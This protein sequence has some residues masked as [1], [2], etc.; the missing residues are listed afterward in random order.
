MSTTPFD[1]RDQ[2]PF[3]RVTYAFA[4]AW[5]RMTWL[6]FTGPQARPRQW[7][8]WG[9]LVLLSGAVGSD[10]GSQVLFPGDFSS[11]RRAIGLPGL[12]ELRFLVLLLGVGSLLAV[13]V[14][15]LT[16]R[17]GFALLEAVLSGRPRLRG[18]FASTA[19]P[20]LQLF[21]AQ[22]VAGLIWLVLLVPAIVA[23]WPAIGSV[24]N[25]RS[26]TGGAITLLI[27]AVLLWVL[28]LGIVAG[29]FMWWLNDLVIPIAW[30]RGLSVSSAMGVAARI[31][32]SNLGAVLLMAL[33]RL[34]V[35]IA[36]G[37]F[38]A[39]VMCA[40]CCF[41]LPFAGAA[42]WM[43][44]ASWQMP[45]IALFTVPLGLLCALTA[46]WLIATLFAPLVVLRQAW[47]FAFVSGLDP[48]LGEWSDPD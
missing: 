32:S 8:M 28:P 3:S 33:G 13:I 29:A 2:E 7:L 21:A 37:F 44:W 34:L 24:V 22:L 26:P 40:G 46:G 19:R 23:G 6:M 35:S 41:W 11:D 10:F 12:I 15:Y 45:A 1:P 38:S 17:M 30:R 25:G 9:A 18:V 20:G 36:A 5:Q 4:A 31:T 48:S 42:A 43:G 39:C 16:S 27:G 14:L 47:A